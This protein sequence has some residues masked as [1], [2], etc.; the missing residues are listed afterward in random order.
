MG[1]EKIGLTPAPLRRRGG[2]A[3]VGGGGGLALTLPLSP[4]PSC[5][6]LLHLEKGSGGFLASPLP[7]SE[8]EGVAPPC[9][10]MGSGVNA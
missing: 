6:H 3:A 8:G 2:R 1:W 10:Q 4:H 5:G 7:L 9:L